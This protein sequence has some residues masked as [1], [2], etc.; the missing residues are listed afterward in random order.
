MAAVV[1]RDLKCWRHLRHRL[2]GLH[3]TA[4]HR[5]AGRSTDELKQRIATR[6]PA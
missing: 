1:G 5:R 4:A 2:F 6:R 3:H